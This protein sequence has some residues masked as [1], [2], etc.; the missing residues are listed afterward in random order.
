MSLSITRRLLLGSVLLYPL[1]AAAQETTDPNAAPPELPAPQAPDSKTEEDAT[2]QLAE[3][4][5]RTGGRLGVSVLDTET[6]ISLGYHEAERFPL[7]STYK[8][9]A[10]GF[11]LARVDQGKEQLDRRVT[12]G[13]DVLVSYSP[14]TEKHAGAD[15]MTLAELCEAAITLSDNTAGNL[16]LDSFGGP[17]ALTDWL[18]TTG[19]DQT[20]L[21]RRE[22]DLNEAKKDDP[23][24]TTT[25]DAALDT[26]G[27]L[28]LGNTLSDA[29]SARLTEWLVA[30]K[31][32]G[33]RIKAGVP[34]AWKTGDKTGTGENGSAADIAILWP[35]DR[36][37]ILVAVY[38]TGAAVPTKDLNGVFADIGKM[39]VAMVG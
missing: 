36:G 15:G 4:E 27:L 28:A 2:R 17:Q 29:S 31:T 30:S 13:K 8:A 25:P 18:R 10:A 23:R 20:R 1:A 37:P 11:V 12:F 24:D 16:L 38:I 35:P 9:L 7:C 6:N 22:P 34:A 19:D 32:G 5:K 21:D 39:V 14:V 3:I 26:L 33:D